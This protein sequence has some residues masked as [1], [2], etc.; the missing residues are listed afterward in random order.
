[1]QESSVRR[2][3][4][5]N[6]SLA[7]LGI[8]AA[9]HVLAMTTSDPDLWGHVR[10]G[11]DMVAARAMVT[12][13]PY[14]YLTASQTW[15]NHEWLAEVLFAL[16]WLGGGAAGLIA[17]KTAVGGLTLAVL[18]QHLRAL[19]L[20]GVRAASILLLLGAPLF[21]PFFT[22]VRPQIFTFLLF[23]LTLLAIRRAESG[24]YRWLWAAPPLTAAW[25]NLHGGVLAGLGM[26]ALWALL[27]LPRHWEARRRILWPA[28]ATLGALLLNPYGAGLP[29]FLLHTATV[30]RPEIEDWQPLRLLSIPGAMHLLLIATMAAGLAFSRRPR[31]TYTWVACALAVALPFASVRHIPLAAIIAV[32]FAAEHVA[33][34]W[35]R[36]IARLGRTVSDD[37]PLGLSALV[38]TVALGL[39]A[40]TAAQGH[41]TRIQILGPLRVPAAAVKLLAESG[42]TGNLVVDFNWGQYAIWHLGPRIKVSMDG[43]RE[44]VYPPRIYDQ[45]IDFAF[46]Q[47]DWSALL[48]EAPTDM[49]LV[50][51]GHP[52]ANLLRL[53]PDWQVAY[54][55][56]DSVLFVRRAAAIAPRLLEVARGFNA[57]EPAREFP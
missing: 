45:Y 37:A 30:P 43:R 57:P 33:D 50:G 48:R 31:T 34:A 12:T 19:Q 54:E 25:I 17:L 39:V 53:R 7:G 55:D 1:M 35:L 15:I 4:A 13:D 14:S 26:L 40:G 28:A 51:N 36:S 8:A 46:G 27:H 47:D 38:V 9:T 5:W 32:T 21:F 24:D 22:M 2:A 23:A 10:Y 6:G 56:A 49:A 44:T 42:V 20:P 41:F 11:L 16:A 3:T 18:W 52:P 29:V